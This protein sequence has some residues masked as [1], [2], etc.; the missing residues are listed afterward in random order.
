M[1]SMNLYKYESI[2]YLHLTFLGKV[3]GHVK[4]KSGSIEIIGVEYHRQFITTRY[5]FL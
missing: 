2:Q 4:S 1:L 3:L 5:R